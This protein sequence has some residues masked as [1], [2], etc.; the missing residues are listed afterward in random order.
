MM[1]RSFT[2]LSLFVLA[3]APLAAQMKDHDADKK[4]GGGALPAGWMG[5]TDR[6]DAKLSDA[7]FEK[8]GADYSVTSGPAAIYWK[9]N[10]VTGPFTAT[11][12]F[13]QIK[14]P[15]HP[16]AYG[17]FF[18][19]KDLV[20]PQQTYFYFL[21]RGDGKFTV[22][23]R[24]G[25]D[26]HTLMDWTDNAAVNKQ[27]ANGKATNKLTV[28]A[29][30]TDSVRLLVNGKQVDAL[31]RSNVGV[32]DGAL[33]LRVNHNLDV[34]VSDFTVT[35]K[36]SAVSVAPVKKGGKKTAKAKG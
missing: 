30:G 24:A 28:D 16:E 22:K 18:T 8:K 5:R 36:K 10:N 32:T 1:R 7:K 6:D 12:T 14:A 19:G 11:A 15:A 13:A 34:Q 3:A 21:V 29:S 2:T 31:A 17:L 9:D 20:S 26:V 4:A 35:P 23:H 25:K 27:D 33:G